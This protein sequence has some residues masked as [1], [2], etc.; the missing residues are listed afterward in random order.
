MGIFHGFGQKSQ[1]IFL[2]VFDLSKIGLEILLDYGL[3][4]KK[5]LKDDKNVTF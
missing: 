5:A 4:R 1:N 3:G 2:L